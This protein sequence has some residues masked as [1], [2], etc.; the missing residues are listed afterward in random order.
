MGRRP[1]LFIGYKEGSKLRPV[2]DLALMEYITG[3]Q[4]FDVNDPEGK[5]SEAGP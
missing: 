2:D 3:Q 4:E 1:I 5:D